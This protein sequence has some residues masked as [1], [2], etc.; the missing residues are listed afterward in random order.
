MRQ[1]VIL[2][3]AGASINEAGIYMAYGHICEST[4][5]VGGTGYFYKGC[6]CRSTE[7]ISKRTEQYI[8]RSHI[9]TTTTWGFRK[10]N[11]SYA[12]IIPT[13]W[14]VYIYRGNSWSASDPVYIAVGYIYS[15]YVYIY[16]V[17]EVTK[18]VA[19]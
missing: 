14:D 9:Y 19:S 1:Q 4:T 12:H 18:F 8:W 15:T 5:G 11:M 2:Y 7:Q 3:E 13:A 16:S 10:S 17:D 6:R